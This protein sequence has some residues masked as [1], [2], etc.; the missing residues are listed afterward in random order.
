MDRHDL[1]GG[2]R[3]EFRLDAGEQNALALFFAKAV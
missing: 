2:Q 3:S 1:P